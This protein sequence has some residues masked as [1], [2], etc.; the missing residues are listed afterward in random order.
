MAIALSPDQGLYRWTSFQRRAKLEGRVLA[1]RLATGRAFSA[2][3]FLEVSGSGG[4]DRLRPA[5]WICLEINGFEYPWRSAALGLGMPG[6]RA[7][8][9][10][11]GARALW[12]WRAVCLELSCGAAESLEVGGIVA[13]HPWGAACLSRGSSSRSAASGRGFA[14]E[15]RLWWAVSRPDRRAGSRIPL[16]VRL[17]GETSLEISGIGSGKPSRSPA[18]DREI[19]GDQRL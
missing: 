2:A 5:I 6:G 12:F 19:P 11:G 4:R 18:L 1:R 3:V 13:L 14:P 15:Q 10:W 7:T 17:W 9:T 8:S 16:G